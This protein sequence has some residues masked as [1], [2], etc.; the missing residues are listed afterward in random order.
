MRPLAPLT[1]LILAAFLAFPGTA[2][3][4]PPPGGKKAISAA[5]FK[6]DAAQ[7]ASLKAAQFEVKK[8]RSVAFSGE[9]AVA[10]DAEL[11]AKADIAVNDSGEVIYTTDNLPEGKTLVPPAALVPL[12]RGLLPFARA[13][14]L[15]PAAVGQTL[16]DWGMPSQ[17]NGRHLLNPDG[18]ATYY[19][20][21]FFEG[22]NGKQDAAAHVTGERLSASLT[23]F[24][25]AFNQAFDKNSPDV[26]AK[27]LERAFAMLNGRR[28]GETPLT[29]MNGGAFVAPTDWAAKLSKAKGDP[30]ALAAL[31]ALQRTRYHQDRDLGA[32]QPPSPE[33]KKKKK[34][35]PESTDPP[36]QL[37]LA[38]LL[39]ALDKLNGAP[40]TADQQE[41]L[42]KSFP[43]GETVWRMNAPTLWRAGLT[44]KGVK[45]A[46]I[47]S[48]VGYSPDLDA[49][50]MDRQ[51][52]TRDRGGA[53]VGEH[54]THVAGTIL[55]LAP[56]AELR[57]YRALPDKSPKESSRLAQESDEIDRALGDAVTKAVADGN[58]V[59]NMSLGGRG[60][61]TGALNALIE[62]YAEQGVIFVIAAGND[63]NGGPTGVDAP[64]NASKVITVGAVDSNNRYSRF[65]SSGSVWDPTTLSYTV[66]KIIMAP[67]E[68]INSSAPA[69]SNAKDPHQTMSG[70]SMAT[71]H[72]AG[73]ATLLVQKVLGTPG[74]GAAVRDAIDRSGTDMDARDLPPDIQPDQEF[75]MV[76]PM[77]AY[78]MLRGGPAAP[79]G[80]GK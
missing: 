12:L 54:A 63:G 62:K 31:Q 24:D 77:A 68:D 6:P 20:V 32:A 11:L 66:K 26:G 1:A 29:P 21:M 3:A 28:P 7:T 56:D 16:R 15:S 67:G 33:V 55:A 48:G 46:V 61:P 43:M 39:S 37:S 79:A 74:A 69:T 72:V 76:N 25:S 22:L 75:V 60:R 65:S 52:F 44:G 78:R 47:D 14:A 70:T 19:G 10:L 80:V 34:G 2:A 57:S 51:N 50:V 17:F 36:S 64:G 71:P 49:R 45:V 41:W 5:A 27:D 53:R 38:G 40:L 23:L 59:I 9:Q 13:K 73:L 30:T 58:S 18:T 4:K 35:E 8:D 42:V